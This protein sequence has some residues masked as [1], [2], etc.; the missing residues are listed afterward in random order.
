MLIQDLLHAFAF[1]AAVAVA[2]AAAAAAFVV[3][4]TPTREAFRRWLL[5]LVNSLQA[6][7]F[8]SRQAEAE[9]QQLQHQQ[10]Q[11]Q[12]ELAVSNATHAAATALADPEQPTAADSPTSG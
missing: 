6:L 1:A 9:L 3:E 7:Q 5:L 12:Q 11:L 8:T 10:Q 2:A 4:E